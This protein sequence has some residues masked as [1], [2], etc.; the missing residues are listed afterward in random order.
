MR[1]NQLG[2]F[3]KLGL[4][5]AQAI[6]VIDAAAV[7][8]FDGNIVTEARIA[9]GSLAPTIVRAGTAE[10]FLTGKTLTPEVCAQAAAM[11]CAAVAPIDDVR[12]SAAYRLQTLHNLLAH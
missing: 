3:I 9:L 5:R 12:G 6:S 10:D 2:R 4:R 7:L 11:A 1:E 8:T